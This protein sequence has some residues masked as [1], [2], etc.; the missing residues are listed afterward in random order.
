MIA[1]ARDPRG[2]PAVSRATWALFAASNL[3]TVAYALLTLQDWA[4]A[5][6]FGANTGCCL[7]ILGLT[8]LKRAQ[9]QRRSAGLLHLAGKK[10]A[11]RSRLARGSV[12]SG[13][14]M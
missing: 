11:T 12:L 7:M 13:S 6:V 8:T 3:S 9:L 4:M 5:A 2:A 14:R 10:P 1:V